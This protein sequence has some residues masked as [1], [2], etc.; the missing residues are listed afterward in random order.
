[1]IKFLL[2]I[3][4]S[5][6]TPALA[7]VPPP[8]AHDPGPRGGTPDAGNPIAGIN[9]RQTK[10]FQDGLAEF[11]K[12]EQVADGLGPRFNLNQCSG[13]HAQPAV[14]GTSPAQNPAIGVASLMGASNKV[15][16]FITP[17]GP[18]REMRFKFQ[19]DSN[20]NATT[21][22]DGGVHD[23]FVITGRTDAPGCNIIQ[24]NLNQ[25]YKAGNGA[26]R[27]PT[28]VFGAGLIE[29][30]P[31]TRITT[32]QADN[33]AAK[34]ALGISG[35]PNRS[36]NDGTIT[37]FGWKAQNKSLLMFSGEAYNVEM[38]VSNDLFPQKRDDTYTC[39][40][41]T[42]TRGTQ[43]DN[44]ITSTDPEAD[45]IELFS[46]FMEF[47]DQPKPSATVPGGAVSIQNGRAAFDNAG[48][49]LCHT[50]SLNTSAQTTFPALTSVTANLFSDLL[51]HHMGPNLADGVAQG[52][53][54]GDG[55]R[56]APLW[57]LGQ[58]LFFLSDGRTQDLIQAILA[59]S[60]AGNMQYPPSE[61]NA[62]IANFSALP[63]VTQ[64]DLINFL[65][66][67]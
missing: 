2:I 9:A 57:G 5:V 3:I 23:L 12:V 4:L 47:L 22:P 20:G 60:S 26:F 52:L 32:N 50:P 27:I 56:T 37:R 63:P 11:S 62:V 40:F 33:A 13:C 43:N 44:I 55:F 14:G 35:F 38:G 46:M 25:Q 49:S 66:S 31:D 41:K 61:A 10:F 7:Q 65:R 67:L 1:M 59:H 53:A 30:I 64:Q 48:C 28:P 51:V 16:L 17:T 15:P 8:Q 18:M 39:Q 45:D 58:R 34:A 54:P 6:S 29:S 36:G 42:A 21:A 19:L 24:E